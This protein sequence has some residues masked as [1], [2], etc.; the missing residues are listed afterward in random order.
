L[1]FKMAVM[2][3]AETIERECLYPKTVGITINIDFLH[4]LATE[5]QHLMWQPI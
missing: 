4:G 1:S 3:V 5:I 2:Y